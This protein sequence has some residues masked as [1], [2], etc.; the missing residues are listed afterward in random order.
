MEGSNPSSFCQP[1]QKQLTTTHI[2]VVL[3]V[4]LALF[5]LVALL[6]RLFMHFRMKREIKTEVSKTLEQYYRYIE[7]FQEDKDVSAGKSKKSNS[8]SRQL[9]E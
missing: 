7:T 2:I 3:T 6:Y 1:P 9:T 4:V 8:K 5:V